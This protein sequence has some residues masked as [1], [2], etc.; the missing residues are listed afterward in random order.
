MRNLTILFL[1]AAAVLA[2]ACAPGGADTPGEKAKEK[3]RDRKIEWAGRAWTVRESAEPTSPGGNRFSDTDRSAWVDGDGWLHLRITEDAR[4]DW[5]AAEI[6]S[7]D[8]FGHGEY[9][10]LA[11]SRFDDLDDDAV[12]GLFIYP[13][14][15]TGVELD[16]EFSGRE[17]WEKRGGNSVFAA[18]NLPDTEPLATR[19]FKTELKGNYSTHRIYWTRD[20][21]TFKSAH[22]GYRG[23][24]PEKV[25]IAGPI[26]F[27]AAS[28]PKPANE[29]VHINLW[30]TK[31]AD[32]DDNADLEVVIKDFIFIPVD[33]SHPVEEF[34]E[35]AGN[36]ME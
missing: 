25:I 8:T 4:G 15:D 13:E 23:K 5:R 2:S 21:A 24:I 14:D 30:L 20:T 35:G 11:A 26:A 32:P 31:G 33:E 36:D 29:R 6:K 19:Y 7:D 12:L 3:P 9:T 10:F 18:Y 17:D 27:D 16:V 22:G 1:L 28:L 34:S